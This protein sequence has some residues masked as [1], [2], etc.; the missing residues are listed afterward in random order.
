MRVLAL[1]IATNTGFAC[2]SLSEQIVESGSH[3]LPRTDEDVGL[4]LI[5]FRKWLNGIITR[6]EPREIVY[7]APVLY[8]TNTLITLRKLHGLSGMAEVV[9]HD[10][11]IPCFEA[12]ISSVRKHCLGAGNVPRKGEEAKAWIMMWNRNRGLN[13]RDTDESDAL[14]VLDFTLSTQKPSHALK[15]TPLFKEIPA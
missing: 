13:P 1:D 12:N 6:L 11:S 7:E 8:A 4:F 2:G 15:A 5:Y 14:A 9:A 3:K 10:R